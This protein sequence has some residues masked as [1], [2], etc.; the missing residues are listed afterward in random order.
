[1]VMT[2]SGGIR[3]LSPAAIG[4]GASAAPATGS[5][6]TFAARDS[7]LFD[8]QLQTFSSAANY[9][10]MVGP[11]GNGWVGE[12]VFKGLALGGTFDPTKVT[13]TVSDPGFD[14]SGNAVTRYR[15]IKATKL[16]RVQRWTTINS[17]STAIGNGLS[18]N[19]AGQLPA[20][21]AYPAIYV[22]NTSDVLVRFGLSELI[23]AGT[24]IMSVSIGAGAYTG[25][26]ASTSASIANNSSRAYP[27]PLFAWVNQPITRVTSNNFPVEAVAGSLQARFGQQVACIQYSATDGTNTTS[28]VTC[29][30]PTL[31]TLSTKGKP[32][33]VY[34][35]T[36][37]VSGLTNGADC[38][39]RAR[40]CPWIGDSSAVLDLASDGAAMPTTLNQYV[41][42]FTCDRLGTWGGTVA[43]VRA[44]IAYNYLSSGPF[45]GD[46]P[47]NG[48]ALA[49][50][51]GAAPTKAFTS[52]AIANPYVGVQLPVARTIREVRIAPASYALS[53]APGNF[54]VEYSDDNFA[55]FGTKQTFTATWSTAATQ[56][57]DCGTA[58]T[59]AHL[60]WRVRR[61]NA[62]TTSMYIAEIDMALT[63]GGQTVARPI[64]SQSATQAALT[65]FATIGAAVTG[66][67]AW[68]NT[69]LGRNNHSGSIIY[70]M[71]DGASGPVAH[72]SSVGSSA[73]AGNC[74]T[75][76]CP[77]P[78]AVGAVTLAASTGIFQVSNR[79]RFTGGLN[80][81]K[82]ASSY[83]FCTANSSAGELAFDNV[84][85]DQ[86]VSGSAVGNS[87]RAWEKNISHTASVTSA[88]TYVPGSNAVPSTIG[89]VST[90]S[91]FPRFLTRTV[92]GCVAPGAIYQDAIVANGSNDG[93]VY[94]CNVVLNAQPA[95]LG[96]T[97][98][99]TR[100]MFVAQHVYE[101]ASNGIGFN[102]AADGSVFPIKNV[103]EDHVAVPGERHSCFY[104]D[105]D[106]TATGTN[107]LVKDTYAARYN[108]WDDWNNKQDW[109]TGTPGSGTPLGKC[110]AWEV[111][112][113][114]NHRGNMSLYGAKEPPAPPPSGDHYLGEVWLPTEEYNATANGTK[115]TFVSDK[116]YSGAGGGFGDYHILSG[117]SYVKG[118]IEL[119]TNPVTSAAESMGVLRYDLDGNLRRQNGT[120]AIGPYEA[121]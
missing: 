21:A 118:K 111:A 65:P 115:P 120:G 90:S 108:I 105:V 72:V 9:N 113:H 114:V 32:F 1:M 54:A 85:F 67:A 69:N 43:Y 27:K 24:T 5:A 78:A 4:A 31:S 14:S 82:N 12:I 33:E 49:F 10:T 94:F 112:Y 13:M 56:S 104:L 117:N 99:F 119:I 77:D 89:C 30:Q 7:S 58:D 103:V 18:T 93:V 52:T 36:L 74:W 97:E 102:I 26:I 76:I 48:P 53:G 45:G 110:G 106:A 70:L 79:F 100:G 47:N 55:T 8:A 101:R 37:D 84:V 88:S 95:T 28:T 57:F 64:P 29:G 91:S 20:A 2:L 61:T 39:T 34:A 87:I 23:Y 86:S 66:L 51:G 44:G 98:A 46:A 16:L 38:T 68:N 42:P 19:A 92:I 25:S 81:S 73:A 11:N 40:V 107:G 41:L 62:L 60:Y 50:D 80:M 59:T 3:H 17:V 109:F 15:V 121:A 35:A 116:S 63:V 71:D 22:A 83:V 75:D 96:Y 6:L